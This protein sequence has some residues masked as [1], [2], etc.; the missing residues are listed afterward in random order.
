MLTYL[1][2]VKKELAAYLEQN[3][4]HFENIANI[5]EDSDIISPN[6]KKNGRE[7]DSQQIFKITFE[8]MRQIR[9]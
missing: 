3:T 1:D 9:A 6:K 2:I 8:K 7:E 5:T 4:L